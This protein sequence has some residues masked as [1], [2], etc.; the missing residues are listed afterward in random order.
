MPHGVRASP[1]F[2]GK[3]IYQYNAAGLVWK[4][5]HQFYV[6]V[7]L[8]VLF[9]PHMGYVVAL[10]EAYNTHMSPT[11]PRKMISGWYSVYP[12][13]NG[14]A[15]FVRF[16]FNSRFAMIWWPMWW[17]DE[18]AGGYWANTSCLRTSLD[19][20]QLLRATIVTT[21]CFWYTPMAK[22]VPNPTP[23]FINSN[24]DTSCRISILFLSDVA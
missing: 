15:W 23:D 19:D 9:R 16:D 24:L 17:Q 11:G 14:F 13:P 6:V 2:V 20:G 18:S 8:P 10:Q 12:A 3:G 21:S 22:P 5:I 1:L 4:H 7:L